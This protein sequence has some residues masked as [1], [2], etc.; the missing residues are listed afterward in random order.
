MHLKWTSRALLTLALLLA[1]CASAPPRLTKHVGGE[2]LTL[3][4]LRGRVVLLNFWANWCKPCIKELPELMEASVRYGDQVV[5]V[6]VY[7]DFEARHRAAVDEWLKQVPESFASKVAW[8]NGTLLRQFPHP[9]IPTTYVLGRDGQI[10]ETFQGAL[11][12]PE[13]QAAL[14]AA[15]LTGLGPDAEGA[16]TVEEVESPSTP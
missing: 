13:K 10:I 9:A 16:S 15:I 2:E 1:G 7:Y 14:K 5:L 6:A 3:E 4:D 8:G 12:G 11:V